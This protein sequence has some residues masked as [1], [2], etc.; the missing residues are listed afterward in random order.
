M[1]RPAAIS[2]AG[3]GIGVGALAT[4]GDVSGADVG[5]ADVSGGCGISAA[6]F[7]CDGGGMRTGVVIGGGPL[8]GSSKLAR[9][10]PKVGGGGGRSFSGNGIPPRKCAWFAPQANGSKSGTAGRAGGC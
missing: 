5:G 9:T 6:G 10:R 2:G 7:F 3:G 4:G 8:T 1:A